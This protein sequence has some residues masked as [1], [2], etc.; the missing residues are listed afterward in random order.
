MKLVEL[1]DNFMIDLDGVVYVG[2]KPTPDAGE[3]IATLRSLGKSL[4]FLTNDPR[5]SSREY[6]EKLRKMEIMVKP[7]DI[8]TSSMAVA[9][10][11]RE[12]Y[13]SDGKKAYV[14]GSEALKQEI[15][16]TGLR[17][18]QGEE[19]KRSDFVVI[20][21]HSQFNYQEIKIAA[22]AVRNG[23]LFLGTNRDPVYPTE[24]GLVPGTG[25]LLAAIEVA[26]GKKAVTAGK[27]E[28][29]MFE[30]GMKLLQSQ[31]R[32]AVIGDSLF[33]DISGG[34]RAGITTILALTGSTKRNDLSKAEVTPD[35]V[36]NGLRDLL[37]EQATV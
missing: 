2:D 15:R 33:S 13:K 6:S 17:L 19:A 36:I 29:V 28:P 1:F 25:A 24:E 23:A 16:N 35:Y 9:Y 37:K 32:I 18:L 3:T 5:G 27:P 34:K 26:S 30:A 7:E 8:I 14:V 10:Y 31:A 22:L 20:G 11:I 21:G 4:I 12:N